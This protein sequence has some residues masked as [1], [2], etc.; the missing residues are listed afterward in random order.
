MKKLTARSL[1]GGGEKKKPFPQEK[2]PSPDRIIRKCR[3]QEE[4]KGPGTTL[5]AN[6]KKKKKGR[7][8]WDRMRKKNLVLPQEMLGGLQAKEKR[9][10]PFSQR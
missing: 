3:H 5:F 10:P 8:P 6:E 2:G 7:A 9:K 4:E 1:S